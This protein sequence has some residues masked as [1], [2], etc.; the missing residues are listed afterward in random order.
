MIRSSHCLILQTRPLAKHRACDTTSSPRTEYKSRDLE[1]VIDNFTITS[2]S[3]VPDN[4]VITN[5]SEFAARRIGKADGSAG[6]S[7]T[8][9][10]RFDGLRFAAK[11]VSFWVRR[12]G[13]FLLSEERGLLDLSLTGAGLSGDIKL[14]LA[15]DE[16][17]ETYFKVLDSKVSLKN[18]SL[19]IHDNYHYILSTIFS[20]L[21][22]AAVKVS[23][24]HALSSQ[25]ADSC[26]MLD[27]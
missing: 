26:E 15:D 9:R 5:H 6:V 2:A 1:F 23:L 4:L 19:K 21:L 18:L 7:S 12:P 11:D 13:A 16:D 27:W 25:I 14:A 22:N 8:T 17:D 10:V 24:E 20:P 3:F